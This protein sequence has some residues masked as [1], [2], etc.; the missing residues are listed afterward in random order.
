MADSSS[1]MLPSEAERVS[2]ILSSISLS[3]FLLAALWTI[4]TLRSSSSSGL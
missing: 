2:R 3:C 4:S 1:K